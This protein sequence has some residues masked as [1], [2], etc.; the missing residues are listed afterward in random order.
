ME[1][2]DINQDTETNTALPSAETTEAKQ[3]TARAKNQNPMVNAKAVL[4]G[5]KQRILSNSQP[6]PIS[7]GFPA[8]DEKLGGGL[9]EGLYFVGAISSI[10]KTTLVCQVAD[11]IAVAGHDVVIF[12]LEMSDEELIVKS[13]SRLSGAIATSNKIGT[14]V[15]SL[16]TRSL[17]NRVKNTWT[18]AD[19]LLIDHAFSLYETFASHIFI[20]PGNGDISVKHI[21]EQ[22][23]KHIRETGREPVVIIDYI[24]LLAPYSE[25]YGTDKQNVDKTVLE[26]K[27]LSRDLKI[28]V[29]GISSLNRQNYKEEINM[30]AFKE[31]GAIEYGADV[32]LGLQLTGTGTDG[33]DVEEAK[34]KI[35]RE[36]DLK[37]L[38]NRNG[39]VGHI[40]HFE[41]EPQIN[42][43]AEVARLPYG[44][45]DMLTNLVTQY[46]E[47]RQTKIEGHAPNRTQN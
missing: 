22:V 47:N 46:F 37:I 4:D 32:L 14:D 42:Y 41:Y 29:I 10:G 39:P 13:I 30:A 44:N 35:P 33:F 36:V 8:L 23:E 12:S 40:V 1:N 21:R 19:Q 31:S 5:L 2:N 24:Q 20:E 16:T 9:F 27:R 7:T 17:L 15:E 6:N 26:L 25:K 11:Q 45:D 18:T 43:F 3:S 28:P 34:R 38:K